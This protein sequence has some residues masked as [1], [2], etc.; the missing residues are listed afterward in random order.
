MNIGVWI[1]RSSVEQ[2]HASSSWYSQMVPGAQG[3]GQLKHGQT[4]KH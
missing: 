4:Q 2:E 1:P 3:Q